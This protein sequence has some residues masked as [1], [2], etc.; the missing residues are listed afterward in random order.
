MPFILGYHGRP[1][2]PHQDIF[3]HTKDWLATLPHGNWILCG[4]WS[5]EVTDSNLSRIF[6]AW[7]G[8]LTASGCRNKDPLMTC[9]MVLGPAFACSWTPLPKFGFGSN[10]ECLG[11]CL[12]SLTNMRLSQHRKKVLAALLTLSIQ[13][14]MA[15]G[16][17]LSLRLRVAEAHPDKIGVLFPQKRE[18]SL[19]QNSTILPRG[20]HLLGKDKLVTFS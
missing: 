4:G 16:N 11:T 13:N 17:G 9:D 8:T 10:H 19:G 3:D 1:G 15:G 7:F 5:F 20:S 12:P 6:D 18:T 14:T 2:A